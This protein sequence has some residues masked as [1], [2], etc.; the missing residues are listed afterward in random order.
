MLLHSSINNGSLFTVVT[1]ATPCSHPTLHLFSIPFFLSLLHYKD[2][3]LQ[4]RGKCPTKICKHHRRSDTSN[5]CGKCRWLTAFSPVSVS[6]FFG[7]LKDN[8]DLREMHPLLSITHMTD[9]CLSELFRWW[10]VA[11]MLS[12]TQ[13]SHSFPIHR[14]HILFFFTLFFLNKIRNYSMYTY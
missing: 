11:L 4:C 2:F 3:F 8:A 7:S 9:C 12:N 13:I 10:S 6:F 14:S 5:H 1:G